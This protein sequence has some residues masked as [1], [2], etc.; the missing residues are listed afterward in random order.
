MRNW[1]KRRRRRKGKREAGDGGETYS[2]VSSP[3]DF[4]PHFEPMI[5]AFEDYHRV[6]DVSNKKTTEVF[7]F[8]LPPFSDISHPFN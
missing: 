4:F 7:S 2:E 1:R 6:I 5:F 8:F 3:L